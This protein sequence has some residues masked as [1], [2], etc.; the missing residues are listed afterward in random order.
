MTHTP[1]PSSRTPPVR[2]ASRPS[3]AG[4]LADRVELT[5]SGMTCA[6]CA[7]RI[8]K[9][10]NKMPGA[11]ATVNYATER[12]VVLGLGAARADEAVAVVEKAGYGA[13][14]VREG[15]EPDGYSDRV[16][17]LRN[18]LIV[19]ALL[20]VPLGDVAI[21]LALAPQMRFPGWQWVL[22]ACAIPVVFWCAWPPPG[23]PGATCATARRA[24]TRSCR[25]ASWPR[26]RGRWSRPPSRWTAAPATG[27]AGRPA[28]RR[29]AVPRGR[30]GRHYLPAGR[31]LHGGALEAVGP[32]RPGGARQARTDDRPG[33]PRRPRGGRSDRLAAGR[34]AVPRASRRADRDR[35]PR[36]RRQLGDRHVGDDRR[37]GAGRGDRR[38]P[39]LG[40][41]V[42]TTGALIVEADKVGAHTQI[43]QMAAT[44]EQAARARRGSRRWSIRSSPCSCR[45]SS[46]SPD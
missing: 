41:T 46:S 21:V 42:N 44:A 9:K 31:P 24:W 37:A 13:S 27:S 35:R 7:S 45:P 34:R 14:P 26:S 11:S 40:G 2:P 30:L 6:A 28:G 5:A 32:R 8:E 33:D 1:S 16:K 29:H 38:R 39:V 23:P 20:T 22:I 43:A 12:A 4:G 10:L 25:S 3:D 17:M 15:A 19:A 18:R 36:R